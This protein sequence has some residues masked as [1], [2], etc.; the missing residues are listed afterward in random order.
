MAED[1]E[2]TNIAWCAIMLYI[3]C[4]LCSD[5]VYHLCLNPKTYCVAKDYLQDRTDLA[6][7]SVQNA[8]VRIRYE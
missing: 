4:Y 7:R 5:S 3:H 1:E 6:A 8:A 2:D